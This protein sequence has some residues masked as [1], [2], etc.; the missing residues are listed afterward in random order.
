VIDL[1]HADFIARKIRVKTELASDL[2]PVHADRVQLQQVLLNLIVNAC[3]AMTD[4]PPNDRALILRTAA[5]GLGMARISVIDRGMGVHE[6]T[7]IFE[8]FV[9]TKKDGLGLGLSICRSI[10]AAHGGRLWADNNPDR[11]ATFAVALPVG[12]SP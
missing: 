3:D 5:D 1:A 8:P 7:R 6:P 9:S 2:P 4:T 10:V 11:G 12:K